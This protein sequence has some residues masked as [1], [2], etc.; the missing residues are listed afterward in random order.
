MKVIIAKKSRRRGYIETKNKKGKIL[1]LTFLLLILVTVYFSVQMYESKEV[2]IDKNIFES[3]IKNMK[4]VLGG[5]IVGIKLLAKGVLVIGIENSSIDIK[6]GDVILEADNTEISSSS[7][8]VKV[9]NEPKNISDKK[10]ILKVESKNT[11][12]KIT[13]YP[14]YSQSL[15]LYELGLY[16]KDSS[17]GV[18]TVTL[19]EKTKNIFAGLGHGITESSENVIVKI[20]S[21]AIVKSEVES[22]T[23]S[24]SKSPGDIRGKIYKD[25]IGDIKFNTINGIYGILEDKEYIDNIYKK[26]EIEVKQKY[27]IKEGKAT[28]VCA[29]DD[30]IPKSYE[31]EIQKVLYNSNTNKNMIIKITDK[32]L[33]EKTGGIVQGMSGSPIIQDGMLVGAVTHVFLNDPL[34]G[35]GVFIENMIDDIKDLE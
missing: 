28:L 13:V 17:A 33:I 25:V 24:E 29:L 35:Y 31:I 10:I 14:T 19:Y 34:R 3:K 4:F 15:K 21:G 27:E 16:V 7:E 23:K 1:F 11:I 8:L 26:Q 22:I 2:S 18:G 30:D 32:T 5:E 20:N 9:I 12:K 6:I